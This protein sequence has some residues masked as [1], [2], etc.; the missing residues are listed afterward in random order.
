MAKASKLDKVRNLGVVAHIDAGKTTVTERFL[1]YS[2]RIHKIGEVH[3][4]RHADGLDARGAPARHHHHRRGH[5]LQLEGLRAAPHRHARPRRLHHRG[6]ALAARARRR[7]GGLQRRRRRRAAVGDGVAPGR[8]VPRAA[9]GLH[10]QDGSHRRRLAERHRADEDAAGR[11]AGAAADPGWRRGHFQRRRRSRRDEAAQLLG[12]GGG[13]ARRRRRSTRRCATT[14]RR[15]ARSWSRSWP[16]S[17]TPSPRSTWPARPSTP[18]RCG[19][20]CAA[21]ASRRRSCPC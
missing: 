12:P 2:G 13:G 20:R 19:R 8:Q 11:G 10:Q 5:D 14:P 16:T 18:R 6:R 17:T 1:F 21:P 4:G 15:R 9:R 3:E 7:G